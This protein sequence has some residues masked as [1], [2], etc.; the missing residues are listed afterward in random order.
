MQNKVLEAMAMAKAV[1]A[2]E[3]AR[4][5]I[6]A[7]AGRELLVARN[8][9]EFVDSVTRYLDSPERH[10]LGA[11]A[12]ECVLARYGWRTH[13]DRLDS[14]LGSAPGRPS[15]VLWQHGLAPNRARAI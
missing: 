5:G 12:R 11:A 7:S 15:S 4:A 10:A 1:V 6:E 9:G 14:I 2:T 13:L 8:R 3:E